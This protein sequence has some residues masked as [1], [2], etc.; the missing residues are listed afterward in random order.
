MVENI[1]EK[2]IVM[3]KY[4]TFFNIKRSRLVVIFLVLCFKNCAYF[5][6]IFVAYFSVRKRKFEFSPK[7]KKQKHILKID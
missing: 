7:F 3:I 1:I 5:L 4:G 6:I 2:N